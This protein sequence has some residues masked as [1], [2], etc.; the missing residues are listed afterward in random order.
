M[1]FNPVVLGALLIQ[2]IVAR[3]SRLAGAIVGFII[4]TG[5]L[6]LGLFIYVRGNFI[7][8][9]GLQLSLSFFLVAILVWY[10]FDTMELIKVRREKQFS[11]ELR[12][13]PFIQSEPVARFY[14]STRRAW[15]SGTLAQLGRAFEKDGNL[16]QVD[17]IKQYPPNKGS[18]LS[19]FFNNFAQKEGEFMISLGNL[20]SGDRSGW[21]LLTN[22][23]LIQRDGSDVYNEIPL[24][25]IEKF[26]I[27][28]RALRKVE[29]TLKS[30]EE[31]ILEKLQLVPP[32][33]Y[34]TAAIEN[35]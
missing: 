4:T 34:L 15:S 17:F 14:Q 21:Y 22:Q 25:K 30:G 16:S 18:I 32:E 27:S 2:L 29:I 7:S 1:W 20:K 9:F 6:I 12:K 31:I 19:I 28:G 13:D 33:K 26:T 3:L 8:F 35:A 10:G 23:R 5:I 11:D 24:S